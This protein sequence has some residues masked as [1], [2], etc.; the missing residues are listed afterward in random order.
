MSMK[1]DVNVLRSAIDSMSLFEPSKHIAAHEALDRL[2]SIPAPESV[3]KAIDD[4][5]ML[6]EG[7][8]PEG[9]VGYAFIHPH[10]ETILNSLRSFNP[11]VQQSA[12]PVLRGIT[13]GPKLAGKITEQEALDL[14]NGV[15]RTN[16][17]LLA[18]KL[19]E[20]DPDKEGV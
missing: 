20:C 2:T 14:I 18:G 7:D 6:L 8:T 17:D 16:N 15:I 12:M 11:P 1:E 13:L 4:V 9:D 10:G 19:V 3:Q 5:L